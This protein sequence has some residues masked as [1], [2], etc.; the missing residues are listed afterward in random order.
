VS[1]QIV[2]DASLRAGTGIRSTRNHRYAAYGYTR[3]TRAHSASLTHSHKHTFAHGY[4]RH[5]E[6]L[7]TL[8]A[9]T[10]CLKT[11]V[12][13]FAEKQGVSHVHFHVVPRAADLPED[14]RG[15]RVFEYLDPRSG[16]GIDEAQKEALT[17]DLRRYL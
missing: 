11:Y 3:F 10:G 8:H 7:G 5:A 6:Q 12:V 2:P 9:V 13:Q 15:P 4:S 14:R 16:R 1:T 17:A